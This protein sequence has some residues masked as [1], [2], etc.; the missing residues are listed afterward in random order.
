MTKEEKTEARRKEAETAYRD[1]M[2]TMGLEVKCVDSRP[3]STCLTATRVVEK[4][5]LFAFLYRYP[6]SKRIQQTFV[7]MGEY[8]DSAMTLEKTL[9]EEATRQSR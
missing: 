1:R 2:E 7:F 9:D 5:Q 4:R 8:P 3:E 6:K